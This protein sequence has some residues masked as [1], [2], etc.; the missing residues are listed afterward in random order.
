MLQGI[1]LN[2]GIP[3]ALY[4]DRH[5]IFEV[6]EGMLP[7]LEEQLNGKEPQTQ[8][9]RLLDELGIESISA[10]SPQAK[11][12]IERLWGTFQDRLTS[13]LR[14]AGAR[15]IEEANQVL[16]KFLPEYN[17]KFAVGARD[18]EMAYRKTGKGFKAEEYFCF[19][20]GRTVGADNVVR[21]NRKR[22]QVLPSSDRP[23]YALCQIQVQEKLDGS[24]AIYYQGKPL[25]LEPAPLEAT[26]MRKLTSI[27]SAD[28]TSS[29]RLTS[30]VPSRKPALDHPWRGKFRVISNKIYWHFR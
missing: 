5:S 6:N 23:S 25:D 4:H 13:E 17:R 15:T 26:L 14:L 30:S 21:F 10:H 20:Y 24:P 1:V 27:A 2:Q 18:P 22:L 3:L 7:S 16:A 28:M 19:K 8:F 11:G 12:R 29:K 9:G